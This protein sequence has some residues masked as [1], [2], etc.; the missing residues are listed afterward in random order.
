MIRYTCARHVIRGSPP[1]RE[2]EQLLR[3]DPEIISGDFELFGTKA[4]EDHDDTAW[5]KPHF[6]VGSVRPTAMSSLRRHRLPSSLSRFFL[7]VSDFR[8]FALSVCG[9]AVV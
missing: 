1:V 8:D 9:V 2:L 5:S 3:L 7:E 6:M 4:R